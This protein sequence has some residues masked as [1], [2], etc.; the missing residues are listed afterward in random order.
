MKS[1]KSWSTL[2]QIEKCLANMIGKFLKKLKLLEVIQSLS[3]KE[4]N[5]FVFGGK[6][7]T[8]INHFRE[9]GEIK[10]DPESRKL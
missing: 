1:K 9:T 6:V 4:S 3:K 8:L 10:K 7:R 5:D 2:V